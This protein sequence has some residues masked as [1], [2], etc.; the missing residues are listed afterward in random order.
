MTLPIETRG[1][2]GIQTPEERVEL[3]RKAHELI[4][5]LTENLTRL[6]EYATALCQAYFAV[7]KRK[8]GS[9]ESIIP[10]I[11]FNRNGF[12]YR[13]QWTN[14]RDLAVIGK[15]ECRDRISLNF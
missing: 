7:K 10:D 12:Q 1:G 2:Q 8:Y 4:I 3:G 15:E 5:Q 13:V 9:V 6:P 14:S 11:Y